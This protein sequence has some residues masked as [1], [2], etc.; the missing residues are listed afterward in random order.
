MHVLK[1]EVPF[2]CDQ[3]AQASSDAL[4]CSVIKTSLMYAPNYQKDF[5]LYLV[6]ADTTIAMVLVKEND[7]IDMLYII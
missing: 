4:K 6:V 2:I 5:N 1:K 3:V 7:G